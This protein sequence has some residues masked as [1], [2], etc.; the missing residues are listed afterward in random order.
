MVIVGKIYLYVG[1]I[2]DSS[3]KE[4]GEH[5]YPDNPVP[6]SSNFVFHNNFSSSSRFSR[7]LPVI[8]ASHP[9]NFTIRMTF[10]ASVTLW[11][12]ASVYIQNKL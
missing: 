3:L 6:V 11:T 10:T 9:N 4:D 5:T 12:L 8:L 1:L 2:G 7:R